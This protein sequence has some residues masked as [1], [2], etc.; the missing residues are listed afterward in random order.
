MG[1]IMTTLQEKLEIIRKKRAN[2]TSVAERK[3]RRVKRQ[4]DY[5]EKKRSHDW[6]SHMVMHNNQ[7]TAHAGHRQ[8]TNCKKCKIHYMQFKIKPVSCD[9][10]MLISSNNTAS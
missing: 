8:T 4:T 10:H 5:N 6:N 9:E 3:R 7:A 1:Q 2:D